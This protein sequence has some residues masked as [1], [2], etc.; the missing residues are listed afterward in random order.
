MK[1]AVCISG[2][3]RT[4]EHTK[5]S[6][7]EQLC[8]N[9]DFDLY[10][11]TYDKNLHEFTAEEPDVTYTKE[12]I[13][14]MFE[15]CNLK[16]L[17]IE[18]R[19]DILPEIT[20]DAN[21]FSKISNFSLSQQE[22]S[23][24]KSKF[25]PIGVRTYDHLR[26]IHLCNESR[27]EYEKKNNIKYDLVIKTRFDMLYFNTPNW[28]KFLD[29]KIHPDYGSTFGYPPDTFC[30]ATPDIMNK[31]AS[32]FTL[33]D[34]MFFDS[35]GN[36]TEKYGGICAHG[37]LKYIIQKYN[38][39]MGEAAVNTNCFRSKNSLQYYGDYKKKCDIQ[40]MYDNMIKHNVQNVYQLE[41]I[42]KELMGQI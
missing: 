39:E 6:F 24:S 40:W 41:F 10:I 1:I 3:I 19:D 14:D 15:G 34:E 7:Q 29:D 27:K 35:D 2:F 22:S 4:W 28:S 11:H 18:N 36:L 31:Y 12:E 21:K 32:R 26:K 9:A 17:T 25:I 5:K 38:I 13:Y 8:K 23:D 33:F 30:V 37:S 42:K 20:K 16:K